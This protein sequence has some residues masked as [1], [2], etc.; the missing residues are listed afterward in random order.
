MKMK[1]Y[2]LKTMASLSA[3]RGRIA[4]CRPL[5]HDAPGRSTRRTVPAV[6]GFSKGNG[7][8]DSPLCANHSTMQIESISALPQAFQRLPESIR[9][10]AW[11]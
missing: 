4:T 5:L 7:A 1:I 11:A 6:I 9:P 3:E 10:G 2:E 8:A